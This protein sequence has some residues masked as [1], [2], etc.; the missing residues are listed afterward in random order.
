[1]NNYVTEFIQNEIVCCFYWNFVPWIHWWVLVYLYSSRTWFSLLFIRTS[2]N[3]TNLFQFLEFSHGQSRSAMTI[4]QATTFCEREVPNYCIQ[5]TCPQ[6][7]N[8]IRSKRLRESCNAGC[9]RT[10]RCQNRPIGL[11]N[12]DATNVALDGQNREQLVACIAEKRDPS[13][14]TTGRN[15]TPW[16]DIRTASFNK[17]IRP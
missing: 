9:T 5:T 3:Q 14:S 15:M 7:C 6:F 13:G 17:A 11:T 12:A 8:A 4:T 1:M 2:S 16:K 10:N